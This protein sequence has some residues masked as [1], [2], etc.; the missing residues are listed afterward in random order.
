M[1]R[2]TRQ[3]R[4]LPTS[5]SVD[6]PR[7]RRMSPLFLA[8]VSA[9]TSATSA[10]PSH[11][12]TSVANVRLVEADAEDDDDA[13]ATRLAR[14]PLPVPMSSHRRGA[15]ALPFSLFS[16]SALGV[17]ACRRTAALYAGYVR[18]GDSA[19][20]LL[21][22]VFNSQ[23]NSSLSLGKL[24]TDLGA[25]SQLSQLRDLRVSATLLASCIQPRT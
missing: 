9:A 21:L 23:K 6:R 24:W 4:S 5:I 14:R 2:G 11:A 7:N 10:T 18:A 17:L 25:A 1:T 22:W 13:A 20:S 19:H 15:G 8:K 16:S 3:G 12:Y